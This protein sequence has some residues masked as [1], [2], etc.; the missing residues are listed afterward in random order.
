VSTFTSL[1]YHLVFS[2]KY[3]R[4]SIDESIQE[5]LY[6]Y[7]GGI[8][9]GQDGSL[10]E[11]GGVEDHVHILANLSPTIA[12]SDSV[13]EIKANSSKWF[14]ELPEASRRF[15]WQKGYA[16]FTVS[17]SQVDKVQAYIQ[18]QP[19]HHRKQS[20]QEE[21]IEFLNRHNIRYDPRYVFE[22]EHHG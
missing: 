14:N 13:R 1:T 10:T 2:T 20:F 12:I 16:A 8:I 6:E 18:N 9:R 17:Q 7:I 15:Q 21:F 4:R 19:E 5:H 11:I 3:R 22:T